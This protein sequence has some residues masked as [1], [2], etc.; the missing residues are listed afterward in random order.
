[1][2]N[3]VFAYGTLNLHEVQTWL[4]GEE[5]QG[6]VKQ[7]DDYR[8]NTYENGIYYIT[9]EFGET[10]AGKVYEISDEQ[11][12]RTDAYEG[13]AYTRE[14]VT[15]DG[16]IVNVYVRSNKKDESKVNN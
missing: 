14:R 15:I 10:V 7:L 3:R 2:V 11:L 16:E 13:K 6:R 12:K 5:K 1:M 4:W 9:K 8:L